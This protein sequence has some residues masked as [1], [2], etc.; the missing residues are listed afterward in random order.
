MTTAGTAVRSGRPRSQAADDAILSSTLDVLRE[1]GYGGLTMAAVIERAGVSSAT[2][3]RRWTTKQD[4]VLAALETMRPEPVSTDTGSL[5]GDIRGF[6]RHTCGAIERG[7]ADVSDAIGLEANSNPELLTALRVPRWMEHYGK[8]AEMKLLM[9][10]WCEATMRHIEFRQQM[11]PMTGE[12]TQADPSGYS[13]AAL[14][15]LDF[16]RRLGHA[17]A[18]A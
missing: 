2:L 4:L 5:D 13:P 11:D 3:Y 12:F 9:S 18:V 8:G 7:W 14:V 17:P 10:A 16:A 6:L 1:H 15:F